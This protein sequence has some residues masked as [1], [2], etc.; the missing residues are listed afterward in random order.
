M[1][2]TIFQHSS[3]ALEDSRFAL[4]CHKLSKGALVVLPE[5]VLNPF[6]TDLRAMPKDEILR[7]SKIQL[8]FLK[9]LAS[10]HG[11]HF[12]A[13]I[14][15]RAL[16]SK[17]L[18]SAES[19]PKSQTSKSQKAKSAKTSQNQPKDKAI[20]LQKALAYIS[21]ESS[22]ITYYLQQKLINYE[23]WNE[24]AFF[25]NIT[26]NTAPNLAP[27]AT[28]NPASK[29][30]PRA[31]TPHAPHAPKPLKEPLILRIG[32]LK[33]AALFGFEI[34]FDEI[35]YKLQKQGV[36]IVVL[37]SANTFDSH[38]RWREL[39]KMRA[40]ISGCAILR[41]NR[42]GRSE[43]EGQSWDFYGD[44]LI[45]MP[46]GEI[47]DHLEHAEEML[48]VSLTREQIWQMAKDWGFREVFDAD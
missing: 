27:N 1:Q 13:P 19:A 10:K 14:I 8:E 2:I 35:W 16:E 39:C 6:F 36:D 28:S 32:G 40:L 17:T 33:I 42:I 46:N 18:E 47:L 48:S 31:S 44:S 11:V 21:P 25:A 7:H 22:K 5:Y 43:V 12:F 29:Q 23:H 15:K 37:P 45:A 9:T 4:F 41:A 26:L 30:N 3:I 38:V 24:A 34:H 20:K